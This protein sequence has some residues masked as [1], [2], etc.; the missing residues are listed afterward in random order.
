MK[1]VS[2]VVQGSQAYRYLKF[3]SGIHRVQRVPDTESSGWLHTS[4]A[5][6][7]IFPVTISNFVEFFRPDIRRSLS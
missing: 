6:V 1:E 2:F 4:A 3:E 7:V 5:S